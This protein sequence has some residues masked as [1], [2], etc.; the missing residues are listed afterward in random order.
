METSMSMTTPT[1]MMSNNVV[2]HVPKSLFHN[3]TI[4]NITLTCPSEIS[5]EVYYIYINYC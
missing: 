3:C 2:N 4:D 5:K 1:A